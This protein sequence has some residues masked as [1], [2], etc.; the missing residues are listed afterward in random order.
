MLTG[1]SGYFAGPTAVVYHSEDKRYC[2]PDSD[3]LKN[4]EG[5]RDASVLAEFEANTV[6]IRT[7]Q[8][9]TS[10]LFEFSFD[11]LKNLHLHLFQDVYEWAGQTR[12]VTITKGQTRFAAWE[13]IPAVAESLFANPR[14]QAGVSSESSEAFLDAASY[15]F[16]ELNMIHPFREG[17]GRTQ[18]LFTSL[19]AA[20]LGLTLDWKRVAPEDL[21]AA[22]IYGV[23]HDA[24][25]ARA[26]L[27]ACL[28]TEGDI[29][30]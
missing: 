2:Y 28:L 22:L 16:V 13:Q 7:A 15:F 17:N 27:E 23:N 12:Q 9:L 19:W 21:I 25:L 18:R 11:F 1:K 8:F 29:N 6:S 30:T 14:V 10:P 4:L 3:T 24:S 26:V 5:I 20:S